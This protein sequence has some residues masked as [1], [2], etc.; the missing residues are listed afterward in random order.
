VAGLFAAKEALKEAVILPVKFPHWP[1]KLCSD[2]LIFQFSFRYEINSRIWF[3]QLKIKYSFRGLDVYSILSFILSHVLFLKKMSM[4]K[5]L[6]LDNY[7]K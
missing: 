7:D 3:G 5:F 2:Q 6:L 4:T 1:V